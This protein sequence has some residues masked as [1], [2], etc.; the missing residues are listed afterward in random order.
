MMRVGVF[1]GMLMLICRERRTLFEPKQDPFQWK[2]GFISA[3]VSQAYKQLL[4]VAPA[5]C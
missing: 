4:V 2:E 3:C 1:Y 5:K